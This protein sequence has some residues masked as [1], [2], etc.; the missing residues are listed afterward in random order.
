[1]N[2]TNEENWNGALRNLKNNQTKQKKQ[3]IST[4][5]LIK[6]EITVA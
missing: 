3:D 5:Y 4:K 2:D 6:I 1:M